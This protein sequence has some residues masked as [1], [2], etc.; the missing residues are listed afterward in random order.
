MG[1]GELFFLEKSHCLLIE[2]KDAMIM[3]WDRASDI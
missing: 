3:C 1:S 2:D